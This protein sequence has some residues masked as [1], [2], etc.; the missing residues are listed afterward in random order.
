MREQ[1]HAATQE[2]AKEVYDAYIAFH[3]AITTYIQKPSFVLHGLPEEFRV[4]INAADA[5]TD[6]HRNCDRSRIGDAI[7]NRKDFYGRRPARGPQ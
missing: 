7:R 1:Y 5:I 3:D 6:W 4:D 2:A